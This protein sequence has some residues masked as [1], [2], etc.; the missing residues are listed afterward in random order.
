MIIASVITIIALTRLKQEATYKVTC[1]IDSEPIRTSNSSC[2]FRYNVSVQ[3]NN[4]ENNSETERICVIKTSRKKERER[5]CIAQFQ[6]Q[7][8]TTCLH[9]NKM[10]PCNG[11]VFGSNSQNSN[12]FIWIPVLL[13]FF[14]A[15]WLLPTLFS[16]YRRCDHLEIKNDSSLY[17][18]D[19]ASLSTTTETISNFESNPQQETQTN[20]L[21]IETHIVERNY[22]L[23]ADD[24]LPSP[25]VLRETL[26]Q[27]LQ[28]NR[29]VSSYDITL[30]DL[31]IEDDDNDELNMDDD[32][33]VICC[34]RMRGTQT[35]VMTVL[36]CSHSFQP[37]CISIWL[38]V[39]A[40]AVC[41]VCR[42][43]VETAFIDTI[44]W[45]ASRLRQLSA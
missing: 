1:T 30:D 6:L 8:K 2:S 12:N 40:E 34:G 14:S 44:R 38:G 32:G 19:G 7:N 16:M 3:F 24:F 42:T 20:H 25:E 28:I 9:E 15:I 36:E 5:N 43:A 29:L 33:C 31:D 39:G 37:R 35:D 17:S 22:H 27:Q 10:N 11:L 21:P 4:P 41:P 13:G 18:Q 23:Q 45:R 26:H